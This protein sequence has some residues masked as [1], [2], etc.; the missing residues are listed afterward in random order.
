[1]SLAP[2][3]RY[4]NRSVWTLVRLFGLVLLVT[5]NLVPAVSF[6]QSRGT[7]QINKVE[8][9]NWWIGMKWNQIELMVYGAEFEG[10]EFSFDDPSLKISKQSTSP[11]GRYAFLNVTIPDD[12]PSGTYPLRAK[13][14]D[15]SKVI[16]F[17]I[18]TRQTANHRHQG[19]SPKDVI[20]LIT[21]DRFANGDQNNDRVSGIRDE[22]DPQRDSARHGGDLQGII[23]H[24]D[25]LVE[26]GVTAIWLNP[27]L[28]NRGKNSYHGYAATDH[29][30]I[31]PRF[32]TNELYREFV[33]QAHRRGLKVIF[34]HVANHVGIEHPWIK[35]LPADDWFNGTV[36]DHLL[37]KHYLLS[38]SDPHAD[39]RAQEMLRTFWFVD[40]MPDLNQRNERL[41]NQIIQHSL[42]WI[43]MSGLDGIRED[44]YPYADQPFMTRWAKAIFDEY[45]NFNIVGEIWSVQPA[46]LA[47]FQAESRLPRNFET[48]LPAVMDFPLSQTWRNYLEG[49]SK[50]RD[51]HEMY[52]QDF[53]YSDLDNL[54]VFL[55]NHDM[56]RA[57]FHA[58]ENKQRTKLAFTVLLTSR[59]I[60]QILYGSELGMIGGESHVKLRADFPGGF[61]EDAQNAFQ[62]SGR[63]AGQNEWFDFFQRLFQLRKQYDSLTEGK[64][65]HFAPTW[66]DDTYKVLRI[67]PNE[68][69]PTKSEK[70]LIVA[71]GNTRATNANLSELDHHM[72]GTTKLKELLTGKEIDWTPNTKIKIPA[73]TAQ[74]FLLKN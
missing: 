14:N 30:R 71:N 21:P 39:D 62:R 58:K 9:P 11:N 41:A 28:E 48:H 1:M 10:S 33:D 50:L 65:I 61:P 4:S 35:N 27:V 34:D 25:Y 68:S 69:D 73:M 37:E 44:T 26:L 12:L 24:L 54:V 20:Y 7:L 8:P 59:G 47:Q 17:A 45:P 51:V 74:V 49:E 40:A 67:L 66:R 64:M 19:F 18:Q 23:D 42:W 13:K 22:F 70:I 6:G 31:D 60:P 72:L 53:L 43:E 36:E 38:I 15:Q 2:T 46:Y 52:A 3:T 56:S 63:T 16:D 57:L 29:Y 55:D 32:G 5:I